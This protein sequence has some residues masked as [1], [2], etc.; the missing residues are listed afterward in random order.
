MKKIII[1]IITTIALLS[2]GFFIYILSGAYDI[3][4]LTPHNALTKSIIKITTHNS[5]KK[6]MKEIAVPD[7]LKDTSMIILGFKHYNE[8]CSNCHSAPGLKTNEMVEGLYPKP[9]ELYK[10][11]EENDAQEF[12]WII[13]N[14]IKMTSMPAF[15][16]THNDQE[17]WAITAFI[18][19]KLPKMTPDEYRIWTNKYTQ[20]NENDEIIHETK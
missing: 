6:R 20:Q 2:S 16:P 1:T 18:T 14:G 3:S 9:P 15:K 19:Q 5:I 12:F 10:H 8:M 7:N 4:Q 11:A 17:I 13:K